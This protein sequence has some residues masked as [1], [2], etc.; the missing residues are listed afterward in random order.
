MGRVLGGFREILEGFWKDFNMNYHAIWEGFHGDPRESSESEGI[1]GKP[2]EFCGNPCESDRI[3]R[4]L[5]EMI[6]EFRKFLENLEIL[7]NPGK[8][9][10]PRK[11]TKSKEI[12]ALG[13][14]QDPR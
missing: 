1:P 3:L 12:P 9:G 6:R 14:G 11:P 5:G 4:K 10:K 2:G 7:G 8:S 13:A